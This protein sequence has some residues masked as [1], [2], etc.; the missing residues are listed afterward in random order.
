MDPAD[1]SQETL[2]PYGINVSVQPQ[3]GGTCIEVPCEDEAC[4]N[5]HLIIGTPL[6]KWTFTNNCNTFVD[7]VLAACKKKNNCKE[8]C[9]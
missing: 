8:K 7:A 4:V 6:G 1:G 9:R 5:A 2:W 3:H